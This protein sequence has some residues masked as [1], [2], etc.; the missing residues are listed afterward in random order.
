[1]KAPRTF[2]A[3]DDRPTLAIISDGS[4]QFYPKYSYCGDDFVR[5]KPPRFIHQT[6]DSLNTEGE[7]GRN[8]GTKGG[9]GSGYAGAGKRNAELTVKH[10]ARER[11]G[12]LNPGFTAARCSQ[13]AGKECGRC[14][15]VEDWDGAAIPDL[16]PSAVPGAWVAV[17]RSHTIRRWVPGSGKV[18]T[19]HKGALAPWSGD[20]ATGR[21]LKNDEG[22]EY[23]TERRAG[24]IVK[25]HNDSYRQWLKENPDNN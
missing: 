17:L 15:Y 7:D 4:F 2:S 18:R 22:V 14:A 5:R 24:T 6:S 23:L 16:R 19:D 8:T 11:K 1:L 13:G 20:A 10:V 3:P 12:L 9:T 21:S 25:K